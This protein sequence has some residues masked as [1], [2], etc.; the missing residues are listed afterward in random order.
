ML[1]TDEVSGGHLCTT[2]IES[3]CHSVRHA[4]QESEGSTVSNR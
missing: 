4:G 1:W 2:L 3:V